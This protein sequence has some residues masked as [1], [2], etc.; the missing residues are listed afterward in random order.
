M[1]IPF[2]DKTA[3]FRILKGTDVLIV[4][5]V[6]PNAPEVKI[7]APTAS[8][9]ISDTY[10]IKWTGS[11]KDGDNLYYSVEYSDNGEDWV[12][13]ATEITKTEWTDDFSTI[14]GSDKPM[15]RVKVTA[16][17]G[18]NA[19]EV[20][21][22]LFSVPPKVPEVFIEEPEKDITIKAGEE[23]ALVGSAYDLQDDWISDDTKL[24]WSSD[25]Q[26]D[27]G[28][29]E[30]LYVDNLKPG[31][32]AITLKATNNFGLSGTANVVVTVTEK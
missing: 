23:I 10:T 8:E 17:D 27:L 6:T 4:V 9:T 19:T 3:A 16:T 22:D 25:L 11:D 20:T 1:A 32:H 29:G 14:P 26:G 21:S 30:L 12:A 28:G 18:I 7:T 13:L 15:G 5:P 31:K 24:I 2:P